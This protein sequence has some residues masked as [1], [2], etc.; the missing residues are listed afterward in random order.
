MIEIFFFF[1]VNIKFK[2]M[3]RF[4][5]GALNILCT[6]MMPCTVICGLRGHTEDVYEQSN[7][8]TLSNW[9]GSISMNLAWER[10]SHQQKH[11]IL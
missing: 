7:S 11:Y 1:K 10:F 5:V 9:W 6:Q 4:A 2:E 3:T 8:L